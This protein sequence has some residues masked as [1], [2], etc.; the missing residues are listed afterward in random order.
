MQKINFIRHTKTKSLPLHPTFIK[1]I[2]AV[3]CIIKEKYIEDEYIK[4]M[5]YIKYP[6]TCCCCNMKKQTYNIELRA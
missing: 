5:F 3:Q 1:E 2:C 6:Y 4:C